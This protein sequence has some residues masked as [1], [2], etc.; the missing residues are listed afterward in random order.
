LDPIIFPPYSSLSCFQVVIYSDHIISLIISLIFTYS[1]NLTA[2]QAF[3]LTS[4]GFFV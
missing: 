3:N 4:A 2:N 1:S